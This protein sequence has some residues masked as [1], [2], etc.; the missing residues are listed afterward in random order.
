MSN[1]KLCK[2][3]QD[4]RVIEIELEKS[5]YKSAN[6]LLQRLFKCYNIDVSVIIPSKHLINIY[7]PL[8]GLYPGRGKLM[9][10]QTVLR[11]GFTDKRLS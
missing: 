6:N 5:M 4:E 11:W 9:H 1:E 3:C 7:S 10:L 8:I 2:L